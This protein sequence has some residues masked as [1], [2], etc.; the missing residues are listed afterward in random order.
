MVKGKGMGMGMMWLVDAIEDGW[1]RGKRGGMCWLVEGRVVEVA[2][3][4]HDVGFLY[5]L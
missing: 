3:W 5:A 1:D 2:C 4:V